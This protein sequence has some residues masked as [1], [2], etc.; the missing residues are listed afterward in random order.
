M[1][2]NKLRLNRVVTHLINSR[3][4]KGTFGVISKL[5]M[6]GSA[7]R[8]VSILALLFYFSLFNFNSLYLP[9]YLFSDLE[10]CRGNAGP[11]T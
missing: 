4:R 6:M 11:P 5:L 7:A 1:I 10:I 9:L 8:E 2:Y 3:R